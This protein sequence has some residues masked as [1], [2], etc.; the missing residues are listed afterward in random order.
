MFSVHESTHR[1]GGELLGDGYHNFRVAEWN[2]TRH[3]YHVVVR[4]GSGQSAWTKVLMLGDVAELEEIVSPRNDYELLDVQIMAPP[5]MNGT[6][7]WSLERVTSVVVGHDSQGIQITQHHI[8]DQKS[9]SDV[10]GRLI[11]VGSTKGVRKLF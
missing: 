4:E 11:D 2:L 1:G 3:W 5:W 7:G 8:E 9:Y 6:A 10:P